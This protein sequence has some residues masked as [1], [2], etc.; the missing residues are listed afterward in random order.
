[1]VRVVSGP[2]VDLSGGFGGSCI[3]PL[4]P[5]AES[6]KLVNIHGLFIPSIDE[7]R[8]GA[9]ISHQARERD[10]VEYMEEILVTKTDIKIQ[11]KQMQGLKNAVDELMLNN[12]YQLRLKDMNYK[13]KVSMYRKVVPFQN[14]Q[15]F[16]CG[17]LG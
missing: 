10:A 17:Q 4:E 14:A 6:R 1:M 11:S 15:N 8:V 2:V 5:T 12:E 9:V 16:T 3:R 13:E 7:Q